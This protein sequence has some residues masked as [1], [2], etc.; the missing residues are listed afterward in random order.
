MRDALNHQVLQV[1][2]TA[3]VHYRVVINDHPCSTGTRLW[4]AIAWTP[5]AA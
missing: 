3:G 4:C 5:N 1:Q 2:A